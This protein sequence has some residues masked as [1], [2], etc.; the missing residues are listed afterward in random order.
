M[1]EDLKLCMGCMGNN[2]VNGV[3]TDCGYSDKTPFLPSYLA[4]RTVLNERYI[5]GKLL[6]YNGEGALYIAYDTVT[7]KIITIKEYMP[8]TL[9][10]RTKGDP[11]IKV[12]AN[13]LAQYK[14]YLSEF[15]ELNKTLSRMRT[16]NHINAVHDIFAENNTAYAVLEMI[17]GVSLKKYLQDFA[18]ELTW[19]QAKKLFPP[20]FT[21]L[22]LVHN[23]GIV[24]RGISLDTIY[25]SEKGDLKLTGFSII[26]S[27]TANTELA[28][29]LFA[30]YAAPEQ[31]SSSN[32]HGTW[33]DVYGIAAV[34]YRVLTG[35][36]PTE[37]VARVGSDGLLEPAKVNSNIPANISNVIMGGLKLS[38]DSRIQTI[39]E[40]VTRLFEQPEFTED[41]GEEVA[42]VDKEDEHEEFSTK[43]Q[44]PIPIYVK[45]GLITFA[46]LLVIA[47]ILIIVLG[48]DK[49]NRYDASSLPQATTT[50]ITTTTVTTEETVTT[51]RV[52]KP[53]IMPNLVGR[54]YD[55]IKDA[56]AY[57]FLSFKPDYQYNEDIAAGIVFE[58]SIDKDVDIAGGTEVELKISLGSK[59]AK[60]PD[61]KGKSQKDYIAELSDLGI[62]PEVVEDDEADAPKGTIVSVGPKKVGD[63]IDVSKGEV[64]NIYVSSGKGVS[65]D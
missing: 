6:S 22:S 33:T 21:T 14:T 13:N 17:K 37:A 5:V 48:E 10:S 3:C 46:V 19:D 42:L 20:I 4:P 63:K 12:N 15:I 1:N 61:F 8:D 64:V 52:E 7:S 44:G 29:E 53:Y 41:K 30:G 26:A 2:T 23:A 55:T 11:E 32:W 62:K 36:M 50:A 35:C 27:R 51:T 54:I 38:T 60:I 16:L 45:V 40:F 56:D 59:Y 9:C 25:V 39:T 34:L 47:I 57:S 28:S 58:Q 18:G 65:D 43:A 31:Y 24:H 49:S